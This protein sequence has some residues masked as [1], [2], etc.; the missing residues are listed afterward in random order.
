MEKP[1]TRELI[2]LSG[3][4][5]APS[6]LREGYQP[7]GAER[8]ASTRNMEFMGLFRSLLRAPHRYYSGA[9]RPH[10]DRPTRRLLCRAGRIGHGKVGEL[11]GCEGNSENETFPVKLSA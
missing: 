4:R 8:R 3:C 10:G 9:D 2:R 7:D 6:L 11:W 5:E 1:V